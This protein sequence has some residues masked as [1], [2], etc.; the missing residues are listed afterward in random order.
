M[1]GLRLRHA[2]FHPEGPSLR[3]KPSIKASVTACVMCGAPLAAW[4]PLDGVLCRS[5]RCAGLHTALSTRAKCS[6]C[7]RP[8]TPAQMAAGFCGNAPCRDEVVRERRAADLART[9]ALVAQLQRRRK[10]SAAQRGIADDEQSTYHVALLPRNTDRPSRLL[11]RRRALHAAHLRRCLAEARATL[12][13]SPPAGVAVPKQPD[14]RRADRRTP[15]DQAEARLLLAGCAAC[16][17]KCCRE[18]GDHAFLSAELMVQYLQRHPMADDD[19]VVAH[20]LSQIGAVT[21]TNGCVYQG[22]RGC[23]L[24]A[25][26]RADI[27]HRFHCTGLMMLKGQ[28]GDAE[29][30]RAYM[31]HRRG[32]QLSG[33]RFVEIAVDAPRAGAATI[34]DSGGSG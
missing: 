23:T 26:L 20:Y 8:L 34:S 28:F 14:I 10:R 5:L 11:A 33:D 3:M 15:K 18:G 19:A 1:P 30:V 4:R 25:E 22:A 7:T 6:Q 13:S 2:G 17:G 12:A 29:P 31:V 32:E 16:R 24:A 9:A 21:M 27:C